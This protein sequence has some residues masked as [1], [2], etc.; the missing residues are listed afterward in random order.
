MAPTTL[1]QALERQ[2]ALA[3]RFEKALETMEKPQAK[4]FNGDIRSEWD[5]SYNP[6]GEAQLG[7]RNMHAIGPKFHVSR[8]YRPYQ[9]W[10]TNSSWLRDYIAAASNP[11]SPS[12]AG[13]FHANMEKCFAIEGKAIQGMSTRVGEDGGVAVIPEF[14]KQI[15]DRVYANDL[16]SKTDG[17]PATGNSM[18]FKRSKESSRANGSRA[19]GLV[20]YWTAEGMPTTASKPG[21]EDMEL[22]L[23]KLVVIVY[24]TEELISDNGLALETYVARKVAEE[25]EFMVGDAIFEGNGAGMPLGIMNAGCLVTVSKESGQAADTL[26]PANIDKM[27]ARLIASSATKAEWYVNQ[28]VTPQLNSLAQAVGTAGGQVLYRPPSGL[29]E[30]PYGTL[31]GRPVKALEFC[32]TIGDLGDI[33]LA[34]LSQYATLVKGGIEQSE[35]M[36][37]EFLTGQMAL[38][39]TIRVDGQPWDKTAITPFKGTNTV[40]PFITL[41]AR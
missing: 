33:V 30:A 2:E 31:M 22:K 28:D 35:S 20:A 27:W 8:D 19:G 36:H 41:E 6:Q 4:P 3:A 7:A 38:R 1:D 5:L 17:Y 40:S 13:T 39:F 16:L 21:L 23:K 15:F 29:A 32:S 24:L 11:S 26:A 18:V 34:D 9:V 25:I 37:V 14:S 10:R 12:I